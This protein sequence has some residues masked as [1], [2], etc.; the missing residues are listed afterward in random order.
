MV[1]G[2]PSCESESER[3][4]RQAVSSEQARE[5]RFETLDSV[6]S[7]ILRKVK[8]TYSYWLPLFLL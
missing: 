8:I 6:H 3:N 1:D 5:N 2:S 4:A 7:A